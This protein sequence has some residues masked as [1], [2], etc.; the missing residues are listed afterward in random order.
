ML[1][2]ELAQT[3]EKMEKTRSRIEL[4]NYLVELFAATPAEIIDK[5]VY[6]IQ[7]KLGPDQESSELGIADKIVI[8][9]LSQSG[10][11]PINKII[12]EYNSI[13]DLGEVAFKFLTERTQAT[14]FYEPLT[15]GKVFSTL[16]KIS[17]T[18]GIGSLDVKIRLVNSLL[19]NSS[20]LES[21]FLVKLIL[22]NLRLGIANF[23]LL[24]ALT[25][26]FTEDKKNRIILEQAFNVS[27]DLGKIATALANGSLSEVQS[28]SISL[29]TPVRPMLAERA[30]DSLEALKKLEGSG[31]AEYKIDGERIQIHKQNGKIELFTRSLENVTLNFP[32]MINIIRL[33]PSKEM[34]VEGE[35]VAIN[36]D[37]LKYLPFQNLM[38]RRRKYKIQ[39]AVEAFPVMLNLFDL[40]FINGKD[41][42]NLPFLERRRLLNLSLKGNRNN[43]IKL[44]EQTRVSS[45]K[46]ID[47]FM[48]KALENGCEGLMLKN[49]QS[50]YRA[51]ARGWAW[52]KLKKEYSGNVIDSMD[53]VVLGA[54]HG[55]GRRVG[56]YGALLLGT[57]DKTNDTFYTIGKVGTGFTDE[58]LSALSDRLSKLV[59]QEKSSRFEPGSLTMDVWFEPK[60][61]LEIISPE[62][63][64]SPVYTAARNGVRTGNGL[65]LRFPKFSGKIR[66]DKL[67]EDATTVDE[68][69]ELYQNQFKQKSN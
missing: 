33:L 53:L 13:G 54:L 65:A 39:E 26:A 32:D 37:S 22:G 55:K 17:R 11:I 43:R 63:T 7:G 2:I 47:A 15:V 36:S 64:L 9:V 23:T 59:I 42:T 8:K 62:I 1:F 29:F 34:I 69:L 4:T 58:I 6:L 46:D 35:I 48:T 28:I 14:L 40:L 44:I 30:V 18:S 21:K 19:S 56:K 5:V 61:V 67:P 20:K 49:P 25:L 50:T 57:Y 41:T 38:R 52:I 31:L 12:T 24:D 3:F 10:H 45:T 16:L 66:E 27:S 51:G 68:V 60:V